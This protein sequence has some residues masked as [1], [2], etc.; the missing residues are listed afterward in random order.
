M[1]NVLRLAET[2]VSELINELRGG[3]ARTTVTQS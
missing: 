2:T 1:P 3:L